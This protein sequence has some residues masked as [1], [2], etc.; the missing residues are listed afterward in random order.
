MRGFL[1]RV[2]PLIWFL[3]GL[4]LLIGTMLLTGWILIVGLGVPLGLGQVSKCC[5]PSCFSFFTCFV[6]LL[7]S[8]I[9]AN[10]AG[11]AGVTTVFGLR[12]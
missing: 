2:E 5:H 10:Q 11:H 6:R 1:L 3:F 8:A 7:G 4:G 12:L 9:P